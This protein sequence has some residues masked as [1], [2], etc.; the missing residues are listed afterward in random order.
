MNSQLFS[1]KSFDNRHVFRQNSGQAVLVI[2]LLA[3]VILTIGLAVVSRSITDVRISEQ[4]EQA[5]RAYSAAEAGIEETLRTLTSG[6]G[7]FSNIGAIYR[8]T[9]NGFGQDVTEVAFP[10][11][12]GRNEAHTI[13]LADNTNY[14][15]VYDRDEIIVAWANSGTPDNDPVQTPALELTLYYLDGTTYKT[16]K[17]ALDPYTSRSPSP[18]FC[19]PGL[20][21]PCDSIKQFRTAVDTIDGHDFQFQTTLDLL[22]YSGINRKLLFI[23]AR[24]LFA[25][26]KHYLGIKASGNGTSIFPS[27]GSKI[28]STGE[29]G[30]AT[31]KVEVIRYEPAPPLIFDF[32]LY[33]NGDLVK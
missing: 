31:R 11:P 21:G 29:A 8:A 19:N 27:Q 30:T 14:N 32:A 20:S 16:A 15:K 24:I 28:E 33:S 5:S 17:F 10:F 3:A 13:W 23:R 25:T 12:F 6:Q 18:S 22:N 2:L 7:N 26:G 9:I 4:T 1:K